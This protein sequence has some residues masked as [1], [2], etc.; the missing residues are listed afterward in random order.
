ME[1]VE[2][3]LPVVW[4]SKDLIKLIADQKMKKHV[5]VEVGPSEIKVRNPGY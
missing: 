3:L 5:A 1:V 2:S 4:L